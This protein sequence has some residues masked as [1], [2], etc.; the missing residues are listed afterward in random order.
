MLGDG[1]DTTDLDRRWYAWVES[2]GRRN[3]V[4]ASKIASQDSVARRTG[5]IED[6]RR[7]LAKPSVIPLGLH[8]A[9]LI[10]AMQII[11]ELADEYA[12]LKHANTRGA[13]ERRDAVRYGTYTFMQRFVQGKPW[14]NEM[15]YSVF[16]PLISETWLAKFEAGLIDP[17]PRMVA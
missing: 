1:N 13:Q 3:P 9:D 12:V 4:F 11:V 2:W 5:T 17:N 15:Y 6:F 8:T 14:L 10:Q 16:L 7:L